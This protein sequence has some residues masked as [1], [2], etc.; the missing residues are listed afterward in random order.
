MEYVMGKEQVDVTQNK[1]AFHM[2]RKKFIY[3]I[4]DSISVHQAA[5]QNVYI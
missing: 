2:E 4:K 5:F 1:T 3:L